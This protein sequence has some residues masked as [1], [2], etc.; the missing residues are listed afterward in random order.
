MV[1][2]AEQSHVQGLSFE[3]MEALG[4]EYFWLAQLLQKKVTYEQFSLEL[5]S[6]IRRYARR[7]E[8]YWRINKH[9]HWLEGNNPQLAQAAQMLI[10]SR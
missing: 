4:L 3:R 6:A 1:Q 8:T 10:N 7:Q 9:I 5:D 2:E